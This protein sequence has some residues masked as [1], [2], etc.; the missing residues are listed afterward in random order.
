MNITCPACAARFDLDVALAEEKARQFYGLLAE[1]PDAFKGP[2]IRYL[3]L[4][5][6]PKS[7]LSWPKCHK[8]AAELVP[9]VKAAR[10]E[11]NGIVK[12]A[13]AELWAECVDQLLNDPPASMT[14]PLKGNG[15]LLSIV[16]SHAE[17]QLATAEEQ[18]EQERKR[19]ITD[20]GQRQ[21]L[22][23]I[24]ELSKQLSGDDE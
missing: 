17:R 12:V 13:P 18:R 24:K 9:M 14:L 19:G 6:P 1:C 5:K 4:H 23:S 15:Y 11:R 2:L 10:V 22:K 21:G 20:D 8:I 7:A 3:R 16:S